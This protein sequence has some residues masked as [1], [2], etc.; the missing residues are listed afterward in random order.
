MC[1]L[2]ECETGN[3]KKRERKMMDRVEKELMM[4]LVKTVQ[5]KTN[6]T[7]FEEKED[8][9]S[10]KLRFKVSKTHSKTKRKS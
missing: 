4:T 7:T 2:E 10:E 8:E 1:S 6:Y 5:S 3:K 9:T